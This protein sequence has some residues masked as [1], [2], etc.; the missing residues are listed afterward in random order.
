[1]NAYIRKI[2]AV[3]SI[4]ALAFAGCKKADLAGN[5]STGEGLVP[6]ALQSPASGTNVV[7]NSATPSATVDFTWKA[8]VPGLK[9][10]PSYTWV[11]ALKTGSL[12]TPLISL[13]A[14]LN[15]VFS[16]PYARLDS[17]LKAKG[18]AAGAQTAL[19]WSILADNGST[20]LL[21]QNVYN[22]IVTRFQDGASPFVLLGPSSSTAS[23][24]INPTSTT[25]SL[26]FNWTRST[27]SGSIN[28]V[29]Y[30]VWFYKD[31]A[32]S[33]P[34]FSMS[35]NNSGKDS[36]LSASYA[37]LSDSLSAHGLADLTQTSGLKWTVSAASGSWTQWSS[38][39]N[40]LYLV[41]QI[42]LFLAGS[43]QTPNPWDPPTGIQLIPDP[44]PALQNK[45]F[46]IYIYLPANTQFKF[47]QG[48]S[49][50]INFGGDGA[51]NLVPNGNTNL[52]VTNA[53]VY[54]I[55]A[56]I[57]AKKYD[58]SPGRMG[59][60]GGAV[61]N[62]GWNPPSVF[63]TAQMNF[64]GTNNFMGIYDFASDGWK[65]IDG[66]HWNDGSNSPAEVRSYGSA[67]G[68]SMTI[69]AGN[70][71]NIPS[72]GTYK[73]IWDGTDIKNLKYTLQSW[74]MY[75]IGDATA[76]GWD[77]ASP[78]LPEL[79]YQGNG[80]WKITGVPLTG[81]KAFKFLM[82][83]GT[84]DY[85]YGGTQGDTS[86]MT[87]TAKEGGGNILVPASGTYTVTIDEYNHTY[88]AQ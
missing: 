24:V 49:W 33:T 51:G 14:G 57:D 78:N 40:Q 10:P 73:V 6:F 43:F 20:K 13:P 11:A 37:Q 3:L 7:L 8:S 83:K 65:M 19:I 60:V 53:G 54:R 9:T 86:P 26:R 21:A 63:P 50:N 36:I 4:L 17:A 39:T 84:W 56:D 81:G 45:M 29:A 79:T 88:M 62:V 85:N 74:H 30:K 75:L 46:W 47:T 16:L 12:D 69:N 44:R 64:I 48:R 38:Y 82:V 55:T 77:N 67:D 59:F 72:A 31:D 70:M 66:D 61:T 34:V 68:S 1:M 76:G 71:P 41:R 2:T 18:I 27:P 5:N 87:G 32:A 80:V 22:L 28:T 25:D 58:I 42:D 35:S 23:V 15:T 52:Q